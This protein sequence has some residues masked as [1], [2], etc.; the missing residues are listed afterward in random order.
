MNATRIDATT[1]IHGEVAVSEREAGI[2][3]HATVANPTDEP[4]EFSRV[5]LR[6]GL[7]TYME[8]YP[9]WREVHFPTLLRSE[10]THFWGYAMTPDG[11]ILGIASP[12]L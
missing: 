10:R 11:S 3:V 12:W 8:A 9:Q 2:A 1:D 4:L 7:D 5:S 6:L